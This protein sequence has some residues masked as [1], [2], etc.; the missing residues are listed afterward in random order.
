MKILHMLKDYN[1]FLKMNLKKMI[2]VILYNLKNLKIL[3]YIGQI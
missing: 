2:K 3:D 1:S